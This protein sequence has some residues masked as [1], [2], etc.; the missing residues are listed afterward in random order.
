MRRL[1]FRLAVL[2]PAVIALGV[3]ASGCD[4]APGLDATADPEAT[5]L[6]EGEPGYAEAQAADDRAAGAALP[7]GIATA[8]QAPRP[9]FGTV[10]ARAESTPE[11]RRYRRWVRD[12]RFPRRLT[13]RAQGEV[14]FVSYRLYDADG[15]VLR[16][17]NAAIPGGP[18][19][20]EARA[21][22]LERLSFGGAV[23]VAPPETGSGA[24][25]SAAA[26][27]EP[28]AAVGPSAGLSGGEW[29]GSMETGYV[30]CDDDAVVVI[31]E[32]PPSNAPP[33]YTGGGSGD[34]WDPNDTCTY[35]P[36]HPDCGAGG[37]PGVITLDPPTG[38][39]PG[40][41]P[42]DPPGDPQDW[43]MNRTEKSQ[44]EQKYVGCPA[45]ID[46]GNI[47]SRDVREAL[48]LEYRPDNSPDSGTER[49]G[50]QRIWINGHQ[51]VNVAMESKL[52][53]HYPASGERDQF[54]RILNELHKVYAALGP[55]QGTLE[56]PSLFVVSTSIHEL[57]KMT[58]S[59]T[60]DQQLYNEAERLGVRVYHYVVA[61]KLGIGAYR[62]YGGLVSPRVLGSYN[63][64][65]GSVTLT[66]PWWIEH[67]VS[68]WDNHTV[69][70]PINFSDC[71]T[72]RN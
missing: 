5:V 19:E 47:F 8:R 46:R 28:D 26:R 20:D 6:F 61:Q 42:D 35:D 62:L 52:S 29:C 64:G 12:L 37:G 16:L 67:F 38:E 24:A 31:G 30:P 49:D 14:A 70:E 51:V 63:Y 27:A 18:A 44:I 40:G 60:F 57:G 11:G 9:N 10:L 39:W 17:A 34:P 69:G 54:Q 21:L 53:P 45:G 13:D 72:D 15:A 1:P 33:P 41:R 65:S 22:L 66:N 3:A 43:L 48:G 59:A 36:G 71:R 32:R 50:L 55:N 56:A 25:V 4:T 7:D 68:G 2:L 23:A 58:G